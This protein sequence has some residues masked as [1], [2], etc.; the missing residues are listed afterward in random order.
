MGRKTVLDSTATLQLLRHGLL[1]NWE[2]CLMYSPSGNPRLQMSLVSSCE[3]ILEKFSIISLAHQ[4]FTSTKSPCPV[5]L[6]HQHFFRLFWTV[7]ACKHGWSV[8]ISHLIQDTMTEKAIILIG[9]L[10]FSWSNSLKLKMFLIIDGLEFC[11]LLV[12]CCDVFISCVD[13]HS[14]GT[15]SLRRI[16]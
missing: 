6:L 4:Y 13:S 15:H 2:I 5:V 14:N 7:F 3:L 16:H 10:H 8:H 11:Q 12:D 9:G 1:K